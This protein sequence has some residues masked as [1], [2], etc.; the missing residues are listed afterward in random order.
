MNKR[1]AAYPAGEDPNQGSTP[2]SRRL[3]E[4]LPVT[5]AAALLDLQSRTGGN[6]IVPNFWSR[7]ITLVPGG[8]G[9]ANIVLVAP[10]LVTQLSVKIWCQNA[11]DD[12]S[13]VNGQLTLVNQPNLLGDNQNTFNLA[14]LAEM[15]TWFPLP[16]PYGFAVGDQPQFTANADAAM[17]GNSLVTVGFAGY[18]LL[19]A[20]GT[21]A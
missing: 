8:S 7:N 21:S 9:T 20:G 10:C 18:W 16:T 4:G 19:G 13:Q 11:N 12:T 2:L 1:N 5:W 6:R 3:I 17:L 15:T 14:H